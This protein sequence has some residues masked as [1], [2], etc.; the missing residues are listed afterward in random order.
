MASE[1]LLVITLQILHWATHPLEIL[2]PTCHASLAWRPAVVV[3]GG[4]AR[5]AVAEE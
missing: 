3:A 2:L 4:Y 5:G 1:I